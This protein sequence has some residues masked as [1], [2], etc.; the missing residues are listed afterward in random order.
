MCQSVAGLRVHVDVRVP[1]L[2]TREGDVYELKV[3]LS[4]EIVHN[5]FLHRDPDFK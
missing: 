4:T 5:P 1:L 3:G 2:P